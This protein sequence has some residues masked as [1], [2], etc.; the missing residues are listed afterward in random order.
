MSLQIWNT[1]ATFGTFLVISATAI[2]AIVQ[3]RHSRGSN[4]IAALT[5]LRERSE[6]PEFQAAIH[7]VFTQLAEKINDPEFR[8][9]VEHR[10]SRTAENAPLIAYTT[11]LGNFYESMAMLIRQGLVDRELTLEIWNGPVVYSWEALVPITA[12]NRRVVGR[13]L[14]ENFEYLTVISQDWLAKH[15]K[16]TYP[17]GVRR[18]DLEDAWL[19]A[20][21]QYAASR[22]TTGMPTVDSAG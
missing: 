3:L 16:G 2:A 5:G 1:F 21:L 11:S 14:W 19:T 10:T 13:I 15:S 9:Q 4:Q 20:D 7:F 8:Y 22:A 18:I 12:I 17:R 6:R